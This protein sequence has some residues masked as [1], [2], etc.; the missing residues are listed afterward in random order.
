MTAQEFV[1]RVFEKSGC[2]SPAKVVKYGTKFGTYI[3]AGPDNVWSP[4]TREVALMEAIIS[5]FTRAREIHGRP[6]PIT[7][8]YRTIAHQVAL[9]K[10]GYKTAKHISP[11][12]LG[13]ALDL[14]AREYQWRTEAQVNA[15]IQAALLQAAKELKLPEPRLGHLAYG[16]K[17]TH[18]DLAFML[19][20]PYTKLPHPKDW[21]DLGTKERDFFKRAY[22]EGARW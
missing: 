22:V 8:G 19:F 3:T 15:E 9:E 16:E 10:A 13:C 17:F 20:V 21:D 2:V 18:V 12:S 7:A 4:D 6:I 11:H 5:L 14:D 1:A